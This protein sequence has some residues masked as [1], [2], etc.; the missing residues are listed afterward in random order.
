MIELHTM[1]PAWGLPTFTPFGLKLIAYLRLAEEPFRI[2]VEADPRGPTRKFPW[3]VDGEIVLGDS[4]AIVRHL[5][6]TRGDRVDAH[7]DDTQRAIAHV[8]R[9]MLEEGLCFVLLH[10]RWCDE[11]AVRTATDV[12]LASVPRALRP[13]VRELVTRRVR[14]DLWGQGITR[15]PSET[16]LAMG[17]AD[18]DAL[19]TLLGEQPFFFGTRASSLDAVAV[20]FLAVLLVPP[21]ES[22]FRSRVLRKPRLVRYFAHARARLL[23][24]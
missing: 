4:G 13:I 9:R 19:E 2:V 12:A 1:G 24:P 16:V 10:G 20:A 15:L 21:I 14:R 5:V 17:E 8:A 23:G 22:E 11:R 3:I 7:L 6:A 18:L